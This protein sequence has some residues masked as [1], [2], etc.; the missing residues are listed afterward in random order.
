MF[1]S[2]SCGLMLCCSRGL[3]S[4]EKTVSTRRYNYSTEKE[5]KTASWPLWDS[6]ASEQQAKKGVTVLVDAMTLTI[7]ESLDN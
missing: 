1:A 6:H 5:V 7:R 3:S 2:C 4:R